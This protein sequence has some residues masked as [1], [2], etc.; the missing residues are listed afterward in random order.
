MNL[1]QTS[2]RKGLGPNILP[3]QLGGVAPLAVI[4]VI[5]AMLIVALSQTFVAVEHCS[6]GNSG[7]G[8]ELIQT[9]KVPSVPFVSTEINT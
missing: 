6:P 4:P 1:I 3:K 7:G 9:S 8:C 5:F 2:F